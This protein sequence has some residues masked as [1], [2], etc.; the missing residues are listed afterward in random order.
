VKSALNNEKQVPVHHSREE[1][2]ARIGQNKSI[3]EIG[4]FFN[5][6]CKGNNVKYFDILNQE[7]LI[8]RAIQIDQKE[9]SSNVPFIE[10]VSKTGDISTINEKFDAIVSSHVI[11]HQLDVIE[12]LK[13]ISNLLNENGKYYLFVPD[14]RYCFDHF[15]NESTIA[16]V[17][18]GA[19]DK[20][21]KHTLK[22]VI[23]HRA[24]TT[25][26]DA[27]RHW[28][29]DHGDISNNTERVKASIAEF[30]TGVYIDVHAWYFTDYSFQN[31][32]NTL[33]GLGMI[34]LHLEE[35]YPTNPGHLEFFAVLKKT[36]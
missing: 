4:P 23:E 32:I 3:L 21:E 11:E 12:H 27:G 31:I 1:F 6:I 15:N 26:N 20:K 36:K 16:D 8:E 22:S 10:F 17:I 19:H 34:D 24:L 9:H 25:H 33:E 2:V 35:M 5:P 14:K 7:E 28:A 29:G 13:M 18:Q 30:E